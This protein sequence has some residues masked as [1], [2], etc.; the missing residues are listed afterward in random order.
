MVKL[1]RLWRLELKDLDEYIAMKRT[2]QYAR[3]IGKRGRYDD[4]M[5]KS[6]PDD[7]T[8]IVDSEDSEGEY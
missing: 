4:A 1:P 7:S 3:G 2:E 8:A 5:S 6:P